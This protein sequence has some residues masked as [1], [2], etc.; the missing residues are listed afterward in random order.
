MA[1]LEEYLEMKKEVEESQKAADEAAGALRQVK[2]Q[3]R[4]EFG[5]KGFAEARKMLKKLTTQLATGKEK[6]DIGVRKYRKKWKKKL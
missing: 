4:S 6:F 2:S 3:L 5:C 1:D